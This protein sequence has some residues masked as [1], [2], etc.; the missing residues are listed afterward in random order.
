MLPEVAAIIPQLVADRRH[1]HQHPELS[2]EEHNT[3]ALVA[4]RLRKL[5]IKT[6]TGAWL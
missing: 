3:A 2:F 6:T 5:D 1:L 4:E